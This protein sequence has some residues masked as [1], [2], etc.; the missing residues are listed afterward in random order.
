MKKSILKLTAATHFGEQLRAERK[1]QKITQIALAEKMGCTSDNICHF[2]KGD[3]TY[4]KG[5]IQ[6]VFKYAKALGYSSIN[7]EL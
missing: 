6:T 1:R 7:I 3:N 4:G 5:S 2:E